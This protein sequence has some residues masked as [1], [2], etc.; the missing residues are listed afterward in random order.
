MG[1]DKGAEKMNRKVN[2][3]TSLFLLHLL[4]KQL[5]PKSQHPP[6]CFPPIFSAKER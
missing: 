4:A 5:S 6:E 2:T 3:D 1:C